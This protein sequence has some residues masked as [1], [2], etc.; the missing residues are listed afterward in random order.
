MA[1]GL[2]MM[3][4]RKMVDEA[5]KLYSEAAGS[6]RATPWRSSTSMR[7]GRARVKALLLG[8]YVACGKALFQSENG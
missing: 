3:H 6:I 5:G 4:G 1:N 7:Q 2:V 8:R